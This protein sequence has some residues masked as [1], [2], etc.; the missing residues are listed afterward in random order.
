VVELVVVDA[1]A[2]VVEGAGVGV[3][4]GEGGGVLAPQ[5]VRARRSKVRFMVT[6]Q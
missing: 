6:F 2:V 3:G 1:V 4:S 5:A